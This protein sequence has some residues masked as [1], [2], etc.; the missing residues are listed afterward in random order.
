[1]DNKE[2][3][4][5]TVMRLNE[6]AR[7]V[8]R[9]ATAAQSQ[10]DDLTDQTVYNTH[11]KL[12]VYIANNV[13]LAPQNRKF[14]IDD[15]NKDILR[16]MLYYFNNCNLAEEVFP[17]K[18]YKL[19]KNLLI[20][21]GVGVGKTMLMQIFSEYLKAT[22]NPNYFYNVSV[23]QMTNYFTMHNNIDRYTYNEEA[24]GGFE[25]TPINICLNDVGVENRPFYGI[26]TRTIVED[27]LHAR[28]E[29]WT[30]TAV[31]QRKFAHLTTN[32]D[33]KELK[34]AFTDDFGRL[35][36][37]FKTYNVIHLKGDSRR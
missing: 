34:E 6:I 19:H 29:I 30:Q 11:A 16:F 24:D 37:R 15:N 20:M 33:A 14:V 10:F 8:R 28:N 18:G 36:D 31:G 17:D 32:L 4:K 26:D 2:K 9:A 1:M 25:G 3:T 35:V 7:T 12:L 5:E 23:T 22:N 27:F 13:V 21:G